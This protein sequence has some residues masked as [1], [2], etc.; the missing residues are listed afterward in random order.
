[1]DIEQFTKL[2]GQEKATAILRTDDQDKAAR[3]MQAAVRGGFSICEFTLTI[4]G[5][6]DLIREFSKDGDI[7]VGAGTVL[8]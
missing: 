3:A 6:F 1:M 5:A 8:T 4:P 7:V 2:L